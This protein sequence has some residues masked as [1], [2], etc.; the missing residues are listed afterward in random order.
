MTME[1]KLNGFFLIIGLFFG[2]HAEQDKQKSKYVKDLDSS[3]VIVSGMER[4][5]F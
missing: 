2:V 4:M 1:M 5:T 3:I